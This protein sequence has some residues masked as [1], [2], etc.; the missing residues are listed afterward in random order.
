M[1]MISIVCVGYLIW[2]MIKLIGYLDKGIAFEDKAII[3]TIRRV[4]Y[5]PNNYPR[6]DMINDD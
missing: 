2:I 6:H 5:E 3:N 1:I 4:V